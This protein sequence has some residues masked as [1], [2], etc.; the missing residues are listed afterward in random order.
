MLGTCLYQI[1]TGEM[2]KNGYVSPGKPLSDYTRPTGFSDRLWYLIT[3]TLRWLPEHRPPAYQL[4]REAHWKLYPDSKPKEIRELEEKISAITERKNQ[5]V[6]DQQYQDV[7][8]LHDQERKLH[9]QLEFLIV[10]WVEQNKRSPIVKE[11]G[12]IDESESPGPIPEPTE[13]PLP[14][15]VFV[16]GG[17]FQMGEKGVAEPVHEVTLS[18]F[19][20]GRTAVTNAQYCAFL[21]EKGN[22]TE[23]GVEWID[24]SGK[25]A[26]EKCRIQSI[27]GSQFSVE[28]GYENHPVIYVSWFGAAAYCNWLSK[29]TAKKYRLP[30]E[31]EWEYAAR[32]GSQERGKYPENTFR[33]KNTAWIARNWSGYK[34]SGS[35]N[36]D[37]VAWYSQNSENRLHPVA[38][39][40]ANELDLYDMS[41]NVWEWCVDW[42][43]I[44]STSRQTNPTGPTTGSFRMNRGGSWLDTKGYCRISSRSNDSPE[45]RS[46]YLGFRVAASVPAQ[47]E[48]IP[49]SQPV[50][51]RPVMK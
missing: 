50:S 48:D 2:L 49:V 31:A 3:E 8:N 27:N 44:Y 39:K 20:I 4:V 41:G 47:S 11:D 51:T 15:M 43:G 26:S 37:E 19:E 35:D 42:R 13:I 9:R 25:Y 45:N 34:Y 33:G 36:I 32:G 23:G 40:K 1:L 38:E 10:E 28:P 46:Y 17:T 18:D 5:A 6:K 21:N 7:A 16:Q 22:Q 12:L 30:T 24:L 14:D 29:K